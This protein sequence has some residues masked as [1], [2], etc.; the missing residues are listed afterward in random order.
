LQRTPTNPTLPPRRWLRWRVLVG[1]ALALILGGGLALALA[2]PDSNAASTAPSPTATRPAPAQLDPGLA[3]CHDVAE[4]MDR[5]AAGGPGPSDA[6]RARTRTMLAASRHQ[7]LRAVAKVLT[8]TKDADLM[9]QAEASGQLLGACVG[10]GI[11]AG[12]GQP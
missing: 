6:E 3:A 1:A 4:R 8:D 2:S 10:H 11:A 9:T 7:D 12:A 5:V